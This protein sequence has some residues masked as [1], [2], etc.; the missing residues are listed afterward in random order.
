M[1]IREFSEAEITSSSIRAVD[2]RYTWVTTDEAGPS[3]TSI[4]ARV[5]RLYGVLESDLRAHKRDD[6]R[7]LQ[8]RD[9]YVWLL[10]HQL[11]WSFATIGRHLDRHHSTIISAVRRHSAREKLAELGPTKRR[12]TETLPVASAGVLFPYGALSKA[13]VDPRGMQ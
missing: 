1:G 10:H 7:V 11:G 8:A 13:G 9:C 12:V 2:E 4:L 6:V 3:A 5:V